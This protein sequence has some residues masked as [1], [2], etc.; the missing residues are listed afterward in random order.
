MKLLMVLLGIFLIVNS[1]FAEEDV[2]LKTDKDKLSY[3]IG[4]DIGKNLKRQQ[5][6]LNS[7][8]VSLG[9]K[10]SL[11]EGKT[12]ITEQEYLDILTAF[13]KEMTQKQIA[14]KKS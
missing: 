6:E 10:D 11:N 3:A 7:D 14:Q 9:V 5:I 4:M 13:R 12:L 2:V 1:G 8:I